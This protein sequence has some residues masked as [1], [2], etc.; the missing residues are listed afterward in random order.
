MAQRQLHLQL[1]KLE[2]QHAKVVHDVELCSV[3]LDAPPM[4]A[5]TDHGTMTK[6]ALCMRIM[7]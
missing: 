1:L 6:C 7:P 5:S 4:D 3:A 2:E